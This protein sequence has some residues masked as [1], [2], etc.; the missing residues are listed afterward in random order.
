MVQKLYIGVTD[1][2]WFHYLAARQPDEVNFWKPGGGAFRALPEAGL[3][4]FKLKKPHNAIAGGGFFLRFTRLPVTLAWNAFGDKNGAA[5]LPD[6]IKT[7][8]SNRPNLHPSDQIG[9]CI[10]AA[11]FFFPQERWIPTPEDFSPNIMTG[12]SYEGHS[13]T[14]Q[15]LLAAVRER[16]THLGEIDDLFE[17][18]TDPERPLRLI[19]GRVG[20]GGFRALVTDAYNRRCAISGERTLP[21]LE[22]AHIKDYA[23][24]GP[25]RIENGLLL[26][27]DIHKLFD[28]GY[29]TV[30]PEHR[31]EVSQR[32]RE[33]FE[34]GRDYY[35]FQGRELKVR[36]R[37]LSEQPDAGYLQWHNENRYRG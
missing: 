33:E 23:K 1:S 19:R 6:F 37:G 8:Q 25:N 24:S 7:L 13:A 32:I 31:V 35:R 34:N 11:P 26:R 20:Q 10:L 18:S 29:V 30:T 16:L 15:K 5:T 4:L 17:E 22:A 2:Q 36:P 27:S 3:F 12:K 9:C 28:A 21:V 14:A